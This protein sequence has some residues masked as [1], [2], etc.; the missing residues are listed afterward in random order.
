[1]ATLSDRNQR[2]RSWL[3]YH[4]T[5]EKSTLNGR[6][7]EE[8]IFCVTSSRKESRWCEGRTSEREREMCS[9]RGVER[10]LR[11]RLWTAVG[12][13]ASLLLQLW[14]C[15]CFCCDDDSAACPTDEMRLLRSPVSAGVGCPR[16]TR[17]PGIH[18]LGLEI[19]ALCA[20]E[21]RTRHTF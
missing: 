1:V 4:A 12:A 10:S 5:D 16:T 15:V 11:R 20:I 13:E 7:L 19:K 2:V 6:T 18:I 3:G 17:Q 9:G 21:K 8:R 14:V